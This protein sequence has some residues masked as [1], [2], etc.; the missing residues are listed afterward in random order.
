M[1][2]VLLDMPIQ[3][4]GSTNT[5]FI[6]VLV[7][8]ANFP[9]IQVLNQIR[10]RLLLISGHDPEP[11][12]SMR[13]SLH[14]RRS[15]NSCGYRRRA[16]WGTESSPEESLLPKQTVQALLPVFILGNVFTVDCRS[17]CWVPVW[18]LPKLHGTL[19]CLPQNRNS[20]KKKKIQRLFRV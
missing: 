20:K 7:K 10:G 2:A 14:A 3:D 1:R 12:P 4:W 19:R 17:H 18:E 6:L 9:F 8:C 5:L 11:L 15:Q 13:H 16:A